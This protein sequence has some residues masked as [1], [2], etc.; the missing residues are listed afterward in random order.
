[1]K[2]ALLH[3]V[4]K[5]DGENGL[6]LMEGI[7]KDIARLHE[8]KRENQRQAIAQKIEKEAM[9]LEKLSDSFSIHKKNVKLAKKVEKNINF[10][11]E[12]EDD[13]K[14]EKEKEVNAF[15][16]ITAQEIFHAGSDL[17]ILKGK[18]QQSSLISQKEKSSYV[19]RIGEMENILVQISNPSIDKETKGKLIRQ[20][21]A[22]FK[23]VKEISKKLEDEG[24]KI[25]KSGDGKIESEK[26]NNAITAVRR[27]KSDMGEHMSQEDKD[28]IDALLSDLISFQTSKD[29]TKNVDLLKAI[30]LR[31]PY[32]ADF[33]NHISKASNRIVSLLGSKPLDLEKDTEN[34]NNEIAS[35]AKIG[36]SSLEASELALS[37]A[38]LSSE[39]KKRIFKNYFTNERRV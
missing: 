8:A 21:K 29:A 12:D 24:E 32:L 15:N 18:I 25:E 27:L 35:A 14:D 26:L 2:E 38:N 3:D 20:M 17:E 39:K 30:R 36:L 23:K 7:K 34:N 31:L 16:K 13:D 5:S 33:T 9:E 10:E 11:K 6:H 1:L 28:N 19:K 22:D 37:Q 4:D